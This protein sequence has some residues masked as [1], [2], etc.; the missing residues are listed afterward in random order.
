MVRD[1]ELLDRIIAIY[2]YELKISFITREDGHY[3]VDRKL[4]SFETMQVVVA[5]ENE[6]DIEFDSDEMD[7][8][9]YRNIETVLG[10]VSDKI[11]G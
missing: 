3:Y 7:D 2:E 8:E 1:V 4:D 11:N 9:I 6:F 10:L 5:L